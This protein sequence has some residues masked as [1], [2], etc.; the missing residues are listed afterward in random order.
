[1][2][3][4]SPLTTSPDQPGRIPLAADFWPPSAH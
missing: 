1:M 4:T 3:N 2:S